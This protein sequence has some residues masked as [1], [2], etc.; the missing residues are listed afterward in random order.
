MNLPAP[1]QTKLIK[2]KWNNGSALGNFITHPNNWLELE[3]G[4]HEEYSYWDRNRKIEDL[5]DV[6]LGSMVADALGGCE[7]V[8]GVH[9]NAKLC[10][11]PLMAV[12]NY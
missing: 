3:F 8:Y 1:W 11:T 5:R 7:M 9:P 4:A 12:M 2:F 6:G 10:R